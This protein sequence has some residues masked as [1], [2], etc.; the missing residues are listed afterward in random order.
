V[1]KGWITVDYL[2]LMKS[3][4]DGYKGKAIV[5]LKSGAD[6][7]QSASDQS[8]KETLK[9]G[10]IVEV[11]TTKHGFAQVAKGWIKNS[12]LSQG[13]VAPGSKHP[14]A[15]GSDIELCGQGRPKVFPAVAALNM[16]AAARALIST[17]AYAEGTGPCYNQ[18]YSHKPFHSFVRHPN[19]TICG[20][21][22]C[23][24]AAGRMQWLFETWNERAKVL[25]VS[26]F[27]PKSQDRVTLTFFR[28]KGVDPN[29]VHQTQT[30]LAAAVAKLN[31]TWASLPGS[32]YGQPVKSMSTLW[33]KHQE[34]TKSL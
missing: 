11:K 9:F 27:S 33:N 28:N 34:Y 8:I 15:L 20:G 12:D 1:E 4:E 32:P 14:G 2:Q 10:T 24:T 22:H 18:M 13:S 26:D 30:S 31:G 17:I 25:G 23:S 21:K 6:V 16:S 5:S 19:T 3:V 29:K 7:Y